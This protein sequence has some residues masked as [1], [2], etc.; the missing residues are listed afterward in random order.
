LPINL[1]SALRLPDGNGGIAET[2]FKYEDA[3]LHRFGKG[4][5]GF[6][7]QTSSNSITGIR[8]TLV[9]ELNSTYCVLMPF[10]QN[11]LLLSNN[12]Y[13]GGTS[14]NYTY[15]SLGGKRFNVLLTG[16]YTTNDLQNTFISVGNQYDVYG[17]NIKSITYFGVP[18]NPAQAVNQIESVYG[19]YGTWIPSSPVSITNTAVR[20]IEGESSYVRK[21]TLSYDNK[22]NML[23][24][25]IDPGDTKQVTDTY[26]Y[27]SFGQ[28]V[29]Q[30]T[31]ATGVDA[32]VKSIQYDNK[33]F[34]VRQYNALGQFE[35]FTR[36]GF[37]R[38][39]KSQDIIGHITEYQ[40]D[41]FNR[42]LKTVY[43]NGIESTS[44]LVWDIRS[45]NNS[46]LSNVSTSYYSLT[47][48]CNSITKAITSPSIQTWFDSF[49]RDKIQK[50]DVERATY[51]NRLYDSKGNTRVTTLPY[52]SGDTP[53]KTVN[54][55]DDLNRITKTEIDGITPATTFTYTYNLT[56]GKLSTKIISPQGTTTK[57]VDATGKLISVT[58]DGGTVVYSYYSSG[59]LKSV[60]LAGQKLETLTYDLQGNKRGLVDKN[61]GTISYS[62]DA[63]GR[64]MSQTENGKVTTVTYDVV[65]RMLS[66]TTSEG[67]TSFEYYSSG[68]AINKIKKITGLNGNFEQYDYTTDFG[69]L[70]KV[71]KQI[72]SESFSTQYEYSSIGLQTKVIYPSGYIVKNHYSTK[73]E[74]DKLIDN[75]ET[76]TIWEKISRNANGQYTQCKL[77][78]GLTTTTTYD[79]YGFYKSFKAG[80]IWDLQMDFNT[81]TGNLNY[82]KDN[83]LNLTEN[84]TYD[85]VNRLKSAQVNLLTPLTIDYANNGNIT[86][87]SDVGDYTYDATK[88]NAVSL[89]SNPQNISSLQ[90]DIQYTSFD[91]AK[92]INEGGVHE[93]TISYGV[94]DERSK[95]IVK[96]NGVETLTRYY[97]SGYEK[98]V[99]P[100]GNKTEL[101]YISSPDGLVAIHVK[102][103]GAGGQLYYVY[104]DH[105]GTPVVIT[106]STGSVVYKQS[107]D[108]WGRRRNPNTW[109]YDL[110]SY[111]P[112]QPK[113][114]YR[115]Y[116]GHEMLPQFALI[117]MNGRIYD[118]ILGRMLSPDN[119]IQD[120][121]FS[122]NYNRYSYVWNNPLKYND[123]TGKW[124]LDAIAMTVG[125]GINLALNWNKLSGSPWDK[126]VKG[127]EYFA[128]G[129][130]AGE[131]ALYTGGA[132]L[133]AAGGTGV[134]A[135]VAG[136]VAAGG[137]GGL[138]SGAIT[139]VGN[140]IIDK[141][142]AGDIFAEGVKGGVLGGVS[143]MAFGG[144][145]AWISTTPAAQSV[146]KWLSKV[147]SKTPKNEWPAT[148]IIAPAKPL[149][150]YNSSF[151]TIEKL[152][153]I[154]PEK[155]YYYAAGDLGERDFLSREA[156]IY[157]TNNPDLTPVSAQIDLA[158]NK[159]PRF[160]AEIRTNS[161]NFDPSKI[162]IIRRVNG[163]VNGT[164]GGGWEIIYKGPLPISDSYIKITQIYN[165]R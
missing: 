19:T 137:A 99:E 38:I 93:V 136:G 49:G 130:I 63:F 128:V 31:S 108:A 12:S 96:E 50:A 81:G 69:R 40:Y 143:G 155:V 163:N 158:L 127:A 21:T 28:V 39:I 133:A 70:Q 8:Q 52:F 103:N 164:G 51:G 132:A 7:K 134:A 105:L 22:G 74:M 116:T 98:S 131:V 125:G 88:N 67:I 65:G 57:I 72:G 1:V 66:K 61:A 6:L 145:G 121:G 37:G 90:Q 138:V 89:V 64:L 62:Y 112:A 161:A 11:T 111:T 46:D 33:G 83:L 159:I 84:F 87:K 75:S 56:E 140:A 123:P 156:T 14:N 18:E 24:Q 106:D 110:T 107:F 43:P 165:N 73:G 115:G 148:E 149:T 147:F 162:D 142:P 79:A 113:W 86:K 48:T 54:T 4:F 135:V 151:Q 25:I 23:I 154:L 16:A 15:V 17:N 119:Y 27:N 146:G 91:K 42:V 34:A 153:P 5:L 114:M 53:I 30:N 2:T 104:S 13:I 117:N 32:I 80:T 68:A 92:C 122:Q 141:K 78:N 120:A 41:G 97:L 29:S 3:I 45:G 160:R 60:L 20:I 59:D 9:N 10:A 144:V 109:D 94:D 26:V 71:T 44:V 102:E 82:R 101:T 139:G 95:S 129:A 85:N 118:P 157:L 124:I 76:K 152:E 47:N 36:D 77:G 150:P 35:E 55:F 100:N 58:D 126:F